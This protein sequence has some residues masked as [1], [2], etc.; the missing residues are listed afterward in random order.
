[1]IFRNKKFCQSCGMPLDK[2]MANWG[3][4]QGGV[5]VDQY[6]KYCYREGQF[7]RD[8]NCQ[9]MQAIVEQKLVEMRL[10]RFV[11]RQMVKKI[12]KLQRWQPA[13]LGV[14]NGKV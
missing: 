2:Q 3:T 7:T 9:E 6:C 1:M 14:D 11:A 12:P 13:S 10:P 4:D 5:L 8:C